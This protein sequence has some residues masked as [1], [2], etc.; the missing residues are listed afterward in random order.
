MWN[1]GEGGFKVMKVKVNGVRFLANGIVYGLR[2]DNIRKGK[3]KKENILYF[4]HYILALSTSA[5]VLDVD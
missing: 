5:V 4:H 3:N 2:R 1:T